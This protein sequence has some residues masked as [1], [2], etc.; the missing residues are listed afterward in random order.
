MYGNGEY[1]E[2]WGVWKWGSVLRHSTGRVTLRVLLSAC[3]LRSERV[4]LKGSEERKEEMSGWSNSSTWGN[5]MVSEKRERTW[6]L[7]R[8]SDYL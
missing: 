2:K 7:I 3:R 6:G 5:D 4:G 1:D 8:Y